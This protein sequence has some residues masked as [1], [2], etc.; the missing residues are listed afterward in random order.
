MKTKLTLSIVAALLAGSIAAFAANNTFF[1][2]V[3]D[4][5]FPFAPPTSTGTGGTIGDVARGGM[6]PVNG[7]G[8]YTKSI[9]TTGFALTFSNYQA[10]MLLE[11]SGT[12]AAGYV[13]MAP[14]PVDGSKAC[15]FSTQIITNLYISANAG[16]TINDAVTTLAAKARACYLYSISNKTWDQY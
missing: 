5:V 12:L 11:P 2:N 9:P 10:Q 1:T 13:T 7:S 14:A 15:V 16:Q 4:L 3:G 8:S 6:A